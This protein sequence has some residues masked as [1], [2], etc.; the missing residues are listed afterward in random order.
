[1]SL[2]MITRGRPMKSSTWVG[3]SGSAANEKQFG[4]N[5]CRSRTIKQIHRRNTL[6][7]RRAGSV[8]RRFG[9]ES[10]GYSPK[11]DPAKHPGRVS[12]SALSSRDPEQAEYLLSLIHISEPT[13]L[14]S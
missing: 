9:A 1:M 14:L 12:S 10:I 8:A 2:M 3:G 11:A 6:A 4:V 7:A 13:R 5:P